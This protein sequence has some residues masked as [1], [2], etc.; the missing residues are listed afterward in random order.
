MQLKKLLLM[1]TNTEVD[2]SILGTN[3]QNATVFESRP[4][5]NILE[6]NNDILN[7][8]KNDKKKE[9]EKKNIENHENNE[10]ENIAIYKDIK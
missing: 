10:N 6:S 5:K 4:K 7:F 1:D 8:D 3:K 2:R 9:E